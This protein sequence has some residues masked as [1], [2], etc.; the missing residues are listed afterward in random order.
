MK[1]EFDH[2]KQALKQELDEMKVHLALGKADAVVYIEGKKSD[3]SQFIDELKQKVAK[4]GSP[5]TDRTKQLKAKL[6]HLKMQLALGRMESHD[7][8][9][10][11]RS[12]ISDAIDEIDEDFE[13]LA[14]KG[15]KDVKKLRKS[16]SKRA[17]TFRLKLESAT[18]SLGAGVV[19][20]KHE[21]E[22]TAG[23]VDI[24]LDHLADMTL[25]E[26]QEARKYIK[27][28]VAEYSQKDHV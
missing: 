2:E 20:A 21:A 22:D 8:Y 11:Q 13:A 23:K 27:S 1:E 12:R 24:W 4:V 16:F 10:E 14:K 19:V 15:Q 26:I 6:D 28:R 3:F 7:A 5:A 9:C 17:Q 25:T 18:L